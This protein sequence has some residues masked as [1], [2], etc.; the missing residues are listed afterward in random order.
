MHVYAAIII[1]LGRWLIGSSNAEERLEGY[2]PCAAACLCAG[3]LCVPQVVQDTGWYMLLRT[4]SLWPLLNRK[5][6]KREFWAT[7]PV[8][9][10][11]NLQVWARPPTYLLGHACT[12][13]GM[14]YVAAIVRARVHARAHTHTHTHTHTHLNG[15][16]ASTCA[17]ASTRCFGGGVVCSLWRTS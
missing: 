4:H 16:R 9:W 13:G 10:T 11:T 17:T 2:E 1:L 12:G 5:R 3:W 15:A 14:F 6:C 8:S 7:K